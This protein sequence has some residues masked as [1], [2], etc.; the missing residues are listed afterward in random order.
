MTNVVTIPAALLG[1][2][3]AKDIKY[4]NFIKT[5]AGIEMLHYY[6]KGSNKGHQECRARVRALK[7]FY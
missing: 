5:Q 1:N 4:K 2:K 7:A 3:I 6:L